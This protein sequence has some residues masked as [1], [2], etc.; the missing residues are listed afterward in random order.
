[1]LRTGTP[2]TDVTF[3]G[4]DDPATTHLG[5]VDRTGTVVAISSWTRKP[6]PT[7]P[8]GHDVQLRGMAVE[9][10]HRGAGLGAT[11]LAAGVERAFDGGAE[12]VRANAR[13][14]ALGFYR[15]HGFAVIDEGF[16]DV[17]TALPHHRIRL[18]PRD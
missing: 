14:T 1:M 12:T 13:D 3:A 6:C 4:D 7:A 2:S 10:R 16:V 17:N 11:L 18:S 9:P 8:T 15:R 5:L